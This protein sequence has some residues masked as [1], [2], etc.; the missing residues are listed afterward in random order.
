VT[1][2][3]CLLLCRRSL[4]E[5]RERAGESPVVIGVKH[6]HVVELSNSR[7]CPL[8]SL[9][10]D[11]L[12]ELS[13][14][15]RT[16]CDS[17]MRHRADTHCPNPRETKQKGK[18]MR[19]TRSWMVVLGLAALLSPFFGCSSRAATNGTRTSSISAAP[20]KSSCSLSVD[21]TS[22]DQYVQADRRQVRYEPH[23][24]RKP[25]WL[26]LHR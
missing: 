12:L 17:D 24:Q 10:R 2:I 18:T 14:H 11:R 9:P 25:E 22:F 7:P 1:S 8:T 4:A 5:R 19:S 23:V 6:V 21:Q 15:M 3:T 16:G 26:D 20:G 13:V